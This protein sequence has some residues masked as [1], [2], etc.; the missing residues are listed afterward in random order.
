VKV[1][2]RQMSSQEIR[3]EP[4]TDYR[5]LFHRLNNQLGVVLANAELLESRCADETLRARASQVVSGVIDAISTAQQL[6]T[7]V[8]RV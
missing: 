7:A 3:M 4:G 6:R 5:A 2:E 8:E 1:A